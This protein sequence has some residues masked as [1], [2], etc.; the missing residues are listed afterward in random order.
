MKLFLDTANIQE[1]GE[2]IGTDAIAGVTTNPSLMA[3]ESK[4]S[5]WEKAVQI[6]DVIQFNSNYKKHLSVEAI[7]TDPTQILKQSLQAHDL[8][9]EAKYPNVEVFLKVPV[10]LDNL[11][12]ISE[13][14]SQGV[15]VNAT[16]CMTVSQAKLASDAGARIVSFFYNRIRDGKG[17]PDQ[18]LREY[19]AM[20][21]KIAMADVICGSIRTP[22][23]VMNA[24]KNGSHIV[25]AS[26]KIIALMMKH[27]QTDKA[28][29]Q[30]Q[31]DIDS[32]LS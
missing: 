2:L 15:N 18:V 24:W 1:I 31:K 23:D 17:D 25:T 29:E 10:T 26:A 28:I 3:K 19:R 22:E 20:G 21:E 4:G 14:A 16:A 32:W 30:F 5:Y 12:V 27:E 6:A 11:H 9:S 8:L 7:S 13:L